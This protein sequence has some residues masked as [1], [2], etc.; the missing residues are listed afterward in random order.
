M[1]MR[2]IILPAAL[3][4]FLIGCD[5]P[6]VVVNA[7]KSRAPAVSVPTRTVRVYGDTA[8]LFVGG[9][10]RLTIEA[11]EM[12]GTRVSTDQAEVTSSNPSVAMVSETTVIP[13]QNARTGETWRELSPVIRLVAPGTAT[14]R[15]TL[16]GESDSILVAVRARPRSDNAALVVDSFT[17]VEYRV[18]CAWECP[19]LAYA[20][21][22]KLREPTGKGSAEVVAVEF[23]LGDKTTGLC[24]GSVG[25]APGA[26]A[27]V[28][29]IFDYLWSNDLIFVSLNGQP[30]P[31]SVATARAIV[32][33]ADGGY[34]EIVV[35]GVVQRMVTNP[36]LPPPDG[37][38]WQCS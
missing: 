9:L 12:G 32:R 35:T 17:V 18:S 26:S 24:R 10:R 19:Y 13:M 36:V 3:V 2:R 28:N 27:H 6:S 23:T 14:L 22:L 37:G 21:L 11:Q 25:Y 16:R 38:G 5:S 4:S 29:G 34:S 31:A 30:L 1:R 33:G 20:P 15:V 8:E 7:P